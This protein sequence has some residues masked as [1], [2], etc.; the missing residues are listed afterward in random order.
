[1]TEPGVPHITGE[2]LQLAELRA[3]LFGGAQPRKRNAGEPPARLFEHLLRQ[4]SSH[5]TFHGRLPGRSRSEAEARTRRHLRLAAVAP[6]YRG[7]AR[8]AGAHAVAVARS[9]GA[10]AGPAAPSPPPSRP[11]VARHRPRAG[12]AAERQTGGLRSFQG[13][14]CSTGAACRNSRLERRCRKRME[15]AGGRR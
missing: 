3:D 15:K 4:L 11:R 2:P 14:A 9:G 8:V 5:A 6:P 10:V 12:R 1:M 13:R 7:D